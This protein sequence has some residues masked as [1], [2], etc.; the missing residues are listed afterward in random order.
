[1]KVSSI[2][3]L[4]GLL[5]VASA[6]G[7]PSVCTP[8]TV[9]Q[10]V[11]VTAPG[12]PYGGK[13]NNQ[14]PATYSG[15]S[16]PTKSPIAPPYVTTAGSVV[17][18]VDYGH[19][20][21]SVWVYPTGKPDESKGKDCTVA[22]YEEEK[23]VI[24]VI[25]NISITVNINGV[26]ETVYST[27]SGQPTSIPPPPPPPTSTYQQPPPTG[28]A[29][30]NVIVGADGK[31]LYKDNQIYAA[32]GDIIHFDF[33]S[34]NHTVTESTLKEPCSPKEG[35]FNTGF[36]QFNPTNH[37]GVIFRD[38]KVEVST[39]L[40]FYCAQTVKVSHC[41]NGMV[42]G[43]NPAGKFPEFISRAT[44]TATGG[45]TIGTGTGGSY[46]TGT[47]APTYYGKKHYSK[48]SGYWAA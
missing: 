36:N 11:T 14:G 45:T 13:N 8:S 25:I 44:A 10:T 39:P 26:T 34:T 33:N 35:G 18:S 47:G 22:I 21:T 19:K 7:A 32:I 29:V 30:H 37:T 42:L 5:G 23:D 12:A 16:K 40:W 31:L 43:V 3:A 9:Y 46:P 1:M 24:V 4:G 27:V 48:R 41:H 2:S 20:E 6:A 17:T 38:F 28:G 15:D